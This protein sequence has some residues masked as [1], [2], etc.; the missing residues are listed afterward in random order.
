MHYLMYRP[1]AEHYILKRRLDIK[2]VPEDPCGED[3][4]LHV[5]FLRENLKMLFAKK[6]KT[7]MEAEFNGLAD[8]VKSDVGVAQ[9]DEEWTDSDLVLLKKMCPIYKG[10]FCIISKCLGN[11]TCLSVCKKSLKLGLGLDFLGKNHLWHPIKVACVFP[12]V[13]S[14]KF[15]MGLG[16]DGRTHTTLHL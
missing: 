15:R 12:M 2:R 11:K 14:A 16:N 5:G 10:N 9:L 4:F 13:H 7:N 8:F 6:K 3:C 1:P